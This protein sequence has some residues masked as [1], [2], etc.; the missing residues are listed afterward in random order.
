[1]QSVGYARAA[2][3]PLVNPQQLQ[4]PATGADLCDGFHRLMAARPPLPMPE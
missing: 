2:S 3:I 4:I 1:V